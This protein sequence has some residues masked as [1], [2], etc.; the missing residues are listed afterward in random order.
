[1]TYWLD[2]CWTFAGNAWATVTEVGETLLGYVLVTAEIFVLTS[3]AA[4]ITPSLFVAAL[5][6]PIWVSALLLF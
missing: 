5:G 1:M 2:D 3:L 6:A 4:A